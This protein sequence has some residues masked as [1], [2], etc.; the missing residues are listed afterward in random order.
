MD[1][2][3]EIERLN[4]I[5]LELNKIIL[6]QDKVIQD[7]KARLDSYENPKNSRNSSI[8]PS[9]DYSRP[10]RT[11][12]LREPSNKKPGGQPGHE[13]KTLEMSGNPDE[14]IFHIPQFCNCCGRNLSSCV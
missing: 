6:D 9:H 13:G 3:K 4:K 1:P 5:I 7:L 8:P 2:Y 12:S 14:I 11:Q 10:P